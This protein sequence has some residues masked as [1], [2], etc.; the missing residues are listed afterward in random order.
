[1]FKVYK[2]YKNGGRVLIHSEVNRKQ[3]DF[4]NLLTIAIFFAKGGKLVQLTPTVHFKSDVYK[5]I[6]AS[7]IGSA[8]ERKCPDLKIGKFFYEYESYLPPFKKEKISNMIRKG[9]IQS[10]RI[11]IN[12]SNG[13][14][15][16]YLKWN[17]YKRFND[18]SFKLE[19][20]EVWIYEKG[21]IRLV[22]KKQ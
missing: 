16:R 3:T 18:K 9:S 6:Y 14:S 10:S 15:D 21:K 12:N 17:I 4:R 19:I 7:L 2:K 5:K 13:A 11:I 22:F 20:D 1:M 8:Y